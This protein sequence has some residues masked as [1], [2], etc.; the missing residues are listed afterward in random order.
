MAE[1]DDLT[2][3]HAFH[4]LPRAF[5]TPD[6]RRVY[7]EAKRRLG[8]PPSRFAIAQESEYPNA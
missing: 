7:T 3:Y 2:I 1:Q 4:D 5:C 8:W 6:V